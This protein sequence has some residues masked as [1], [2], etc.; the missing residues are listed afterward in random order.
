[1]SSLKSLGKLVGA[2]LV[3]ALLVALSLAPFAGIGG[4]AVAR[5]TATMQSNLADLTDGTAPGVTT[6]TDINGEPIAWLYN[7]RRHEVEPDQIAQPVK[8]ALVAIEDRRFYE[9]DGVDIQ[10]TARALL[11]NLAAGGVEQGASTIHQQYV[12]NYL[13]L[14]DAESTDEQ[15]AATEQ[16]VPRKLREMRMASDLDKNLTKDEI[17][18][19][20]LNVVP[21]GNHAY[22]IEAAAR[23]YFGIS[24]AELNVPQ[25]ALL[26]GM[27]QSSEALNPYTNPDGATQRRNTVLQ[28][29]AEVGYITQEE[30]NA[31][32]QGPLGVLESPAIL[33]NGCISA[34]SAGFLCDYAMEYLQAKGMTEEQL[35]NDAYTVR[36][37][38]DPITQ[39]AAQNAVNNAVNPS[40]PGVAGVLNVVKPGENSRDIAAMVSSRNYGL[41]LE[42]GQTYLPQPSTL[43]GN[44]AGSVFKVFTAAVAIE[45]GMGLDTMLPVPTRTEVYGMGTGGA[46]G[47]PPNAY[48][49]ENAGV[50]PAHLSLKDALAQ[51]PNTTFIELIQQ[52]GVAPTVDMAVKLGLRSYAE[53]GTY[54]DSSI[55]EYFK[56]A[57]LGSFTLGPTA[58]NALELSNVG[59]TLA[60][61]GRWCEP[62]PIAQVTDRDGQEVFLDRPECET[63]LDPG[64]AN[65]V[66]Q[67]LSE[68][69]VS[70]TAAGA[71]NAYGWN[72]PV[73]AKTGTT[74]SHQSSAFLGY[75][76]AI[77]AAPYI[78]ND[79]TTTMSLC[80][81]PV[82]QCQGG[83]LYGGREPAQMWFNTANNI[84]GAP[85]AGLPAHDAL[86]NQGESKT[87]LDDVTGLSEQD[88]RTRLEDQGFVVKTG[89]TFGNGIPRNHVV[90]VKAEDPQLSRGST[91]TMYLSDG[92][93]ARPRTQSENPRDGSNRSPSPTP[94]A[95]GDPAQA[96]AIPPE[97]EQIIRDFEDFFNSL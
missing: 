81:S 68:D 55:A 33:P 63:V 43:V 53:P 95:D 60:S 39:Q 3:A 57:N 10:G 82:R 80:T 96:P 15:I 37:T 86:Y 38:L 17:L 93:N 41:N 6:I 78:F 19:R 76:N 30:A 13:L 2:V 11:A 1:M 35:K 59:A 84:P 29:M 23:T 32:I 87:A 58:V 66:S 14:V 26:V 24:A 72:S 34:G 73:A 70:G 79:G 83:S 74:E 16:S 25:A 5:T 77:A 69:A 88:A 45:Q 85:G 89:T 42:A 92:S 9:H 65:A 18:G 50:Y 40:T 94:G 44:G 75:N 91:V 97:A 20:Y 36:L 47:C 54:G 49:V 21:F 7:Q 8:D 62:N 71:A 52:V 27:V 28:A 56:E 64:V 90:Y 67:A 61:H 48:C 46:R 31:Y 4:V 12:K 51:S 22:G